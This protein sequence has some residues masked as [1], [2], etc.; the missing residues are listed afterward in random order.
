MLTKLRARN[1]K[2]FEDVEIALGNPVVLV[3]P[4]NSGKATVLQALAL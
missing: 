2:C 3:G 1:F 4:N